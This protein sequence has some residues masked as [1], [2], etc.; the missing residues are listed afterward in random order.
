M[1]NFTEWIATGPL[2]QYVAERKSR[3]SGLAVFE[4]SQP[5]GDMSDPAVDQLLIGRVLSHSLPHRSD[6]GAGHVTEVLHAGALVMTPPGFASRIETYSPHAIRA[7]SV[8]PD[9]IARLIPSHAHRTLDFRELHKGG[10]RDDVVRTL[11]DAVWDEIDSGEDA[12]SLFVDQAMMT[13]VCRLMQLANRARQL[14][15]GGLAPWQ[16]RRCIEYMQEHVAEDIRLADLASIAGLSPF[17]FTRAF[18]QSTGRPPF[19]Y[20]RELRVERA[21]ML[22]KASGASIGAV[23]QA[24]GFESQQAF[25]R[26]FRTS[27]GNTPSQWRRD[28]LSQ[29]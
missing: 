2:S 1:A 6:L 15:R 29:Q 17:H 26:M 20:H 11:L 8:H 19:S 14:P 10:F 24:V 3:N 22:L 21:K 28:R 27:T 7:Y 9:Y 5:A 13:A 25:A 12:A 18:R 16:L 4:F 23:A